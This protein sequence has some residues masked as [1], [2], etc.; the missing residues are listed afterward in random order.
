MAVTNNFAAST[1]DLNGKIAINQPTALVWGPDGRLYITEADGDVRVLTV[2]FGDK[3]P[4]DTDNT[5]QFY[6]TEAITLNLIKGAIQN[7]N[8]NGTLNAGVNRQVTGIDVTRQ[9]DAE[10][11]Q[12]LIDGKP[13]ATIYVTSSDI[14]RW[15][16]DPGRSAA[17]YAHHA[18]QL[19]NQLRPF[20]IRPGA[21]RR[22]Q[23]AEAWARYL[24]AKGAIT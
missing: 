6:V 8:D 20:G 14:R 10:G 22:G 2:A 12:V 13:A 17:R 3:N 15:R 9:F 5:A 18:A 7:Y 11:N 24:P 16:N 1:L 23:F 21:T 4:L 19:A